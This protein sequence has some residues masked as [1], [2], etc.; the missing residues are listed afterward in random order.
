MA[1]FQQQQVP[2]TPKGAALKTTC[3]RLG[4]SKAGCALVNG[5]ATPLTQV[6]LGAAYTA[7]GIITL[8]G[9]RM[10]TSM[11]DTDEVI[12]DALDRFESPR[13]N[14]RAARAF[15]SRRHDQPPR[16]HARR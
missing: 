2:S 4:S 13:A 8:A 5:V 7:N 14:Q 10:Y 3:A 12:N 11:A 9:S 15:E 16:A 6:K 1:V